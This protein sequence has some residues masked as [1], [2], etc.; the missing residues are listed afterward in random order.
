VLASIAVVWC[1]SRRVQPSSSTHPGW[2]CP[3]DCHRHPYCRLGRQWRALP[4][5]ALLAPPRAATPRHTVPRSPFRSSAT[6]QASPRSD[7]SAP[8]HAGTAL[9]S[10]LGA[11]HPKCAICCSCLASCSEACLGTRSQKSS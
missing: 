9:P 6:R 5:H 4:A 2:R 1:A 7:A 3:S 11:W 8:R 10:A